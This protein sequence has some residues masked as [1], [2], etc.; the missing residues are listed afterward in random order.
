MHES[1]VAQSCL[2]LSNPMD[3]SLPGSSI[4]GIFQA[5]VLKWAAIAFSNSCLFKIVILYHTLV[6]L[7]SEYFG[8]FILFFIV[9]TPDYILANSVQGF[10]FLPNLT[11]IYFLFFFFLI[12]DILPG[13]R[14]HLPVVLIC[15]SLMISDAEHLFMY[16]LA[17]CVSSYK[18]SVHVLCPSLN[19]PFFALE[20]CGSLCML[21]INL[22]SDMWFA[23]IFSHSICCLFFFLFMVSFT[24]HN[25]FNLK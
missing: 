22:L 1:E 18:M 4:H 20:M 10:S 3:C 23:N 11:S 16:P 7:F 25:L 21:D 6:F 17:I 8:I 14:W 24:V 13:I 15:I 9:A 5:R 12:I 19:C 2:T